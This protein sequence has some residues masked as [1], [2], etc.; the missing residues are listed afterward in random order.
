[1]PVQCP[2]CGHPK[3]YKHGKLLAVSNATT[4]LYV[5]A[6]L[7]K[8]LI[9]FT[10]VGRLP[11]KTIRHVLQS[12]AE[13]SSLKSIARTTG[14]AYNTVVALVHAESV[15]WQHLHNGN[16][17][18]VDTDDVSVDEMWSFVKKSKNTVSQTS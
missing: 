8:P 18:A 6:P 2:L 1:M 13:G 15:G 5:N 9:P 7:L 14:L 12:P 3:A 4:V 16:V 10:T 11:Q 17:L